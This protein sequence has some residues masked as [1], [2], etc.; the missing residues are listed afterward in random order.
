MNK[1]TIFAGL[2][3]LATGGAIGG[4]TAWALTKRKYTDIL[5]KTVDN[6]E[7]L[8]DEANAFDGEDDVPDEFKRYIPEEEKKET[9]K[10]SS[11]EKEVIKEKLRYNH[12]KTT[13]YAAMYSTPIKDIIDAKAE[14]EPDPEELAEAMA[15]D[16][17]D[18]EEAE[19]KSH[20]DVLEAVKNNAR[21]PVIISEEDFND[22]CDNHLGNMPGEWDCSNLFLYNDDTVTGEDD[23]V[24]EGEEL[25][26][27]LGDCLDKYGF[28]NGSETTIFVK[29]F[30][31][32]TVYEVAKINKPFIK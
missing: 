5:N 7:K 2:I 12:E 26:K 30:E 15:E 6:Y 1:E 11:E 31:L 10:L 8:L 19:K 18:A 29:C 22:I 25:A 27:M 28:R 13:A 14:E 32:N 16:E 9:P 3:G 4:F 17:D 23:H 20:F 21:K 24:Y